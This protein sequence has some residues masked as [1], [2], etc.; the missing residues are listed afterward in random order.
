MHILVTNDDGIDSPGLHA[1]AIA[2]KRLGKVSVLAPDR[3]W[4]VSGHARKLDQ[5]LTVW[6]YPLLDGINASACDG[7]P[8]DCVSVAMMGMVQEP[9][10]LVLSGINP[11]ANIG[12]DVTYSGTVTAAM[13][14][15]IY[16]LP[17]FAISLGANDSD[18]P[19][20]FEPAADLAITVIAQFPLTALT[21]RVLNINVPYRPA[22]EINGVVVTRLGVRHYHQELV[23]QGFVAGREK[24]TV[25]GSPPGGELIPG[26]DYWALNEGLIS[27]TPISLDLTDYDEM[28]AIVALS[29]AHL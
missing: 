9:I 16:G 19:V 23:R 8:S 6:R 1:L 12:H 10:D 4:S 20:D 29:L 22:S 5:P 11:H 26:T 24:I 14:A 17:G 21:S 7:T 15:A 2:A 18:A 27:V 25:S 13:E 28:P 3:N